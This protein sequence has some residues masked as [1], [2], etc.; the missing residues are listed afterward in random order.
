MPFFVDALS[1]KKDLGKL[2]RLSLYEP[3]D[4]SPDI[5]EILHQ[6]IPCLTS[7]S[8]RVLL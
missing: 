1:R 5:N 8:R 6:E 7:L 2:P 4:D 3:D